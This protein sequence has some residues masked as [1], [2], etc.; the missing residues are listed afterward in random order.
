MRTGTEINL[1]F[2]T[3]RDITAILVLITVVVK[4][5]HAGFI[6][7]HFLLT[8]HTLDTPLELNEF[9]QV[10]LPSISPNTLMPE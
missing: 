5:V 8:I 4:T 9:P 6:T 7:R 1:F 3:H 2:L 10:F